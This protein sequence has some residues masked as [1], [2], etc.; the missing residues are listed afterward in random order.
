MY[1]KTELTFKPISELFGR[2]PVHFLGTSENKL[3]HIATQHSI[4][5]QSIK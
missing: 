4:T 5:T 2:T 3:N 1:K